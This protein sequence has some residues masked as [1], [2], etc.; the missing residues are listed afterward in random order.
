VR[1]PAD[2]VEHGRRRGVEEGEADE[3]ETRLGLH[4]PAVVEWLGLSE[5]REVDPG[6]VGIEARAPDDV[7]D[8]ENPAALQER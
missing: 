5:G 6:E 7:C 3:V 2:A 1:V 8:L 4:E